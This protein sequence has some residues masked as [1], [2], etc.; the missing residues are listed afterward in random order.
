MPMNSVGGWLGKIEAMRRERGGAMDSS[1]M[2]T[3]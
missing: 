1:E 3:V 2:V